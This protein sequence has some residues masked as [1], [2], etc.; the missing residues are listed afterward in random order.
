[1]ILYLKIKI[2]SNSNLNYKNID[3]KVGET[4][5]LCFH[6]VL[7]NFVTEGQFGITMELIF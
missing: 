6:F 7:I 5:N 2:K 3:I 1:M 4:M